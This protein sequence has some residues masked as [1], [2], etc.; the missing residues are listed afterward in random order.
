MKTQ[1]EIT[2]P[3]IKAP[4]P[5]IQLAIVDVMRDF[6]SQT[7]GWVTTFRTPTKASSLKYNLLLPLYSELVSVVDV[8]G[9]NNSGWRSDGRSTLTLSSQPAEGYL[10]VTMRLKPVIGCPV[11]PDELTIYREAIRAGTLAWLRGQKDTDWFD[12]EQMMY[13]KQVYDG[14]VGD[15]KIRQVQEHSAKTHVAK[16][17]RAYRIG[18]AP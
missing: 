1:L 15:A 5:I 13:W 7:S 17:P 12:P 16:A 11:I 3:H 4:D 18:R 6:C 2:R 9:V 8:G 10:E 14:L